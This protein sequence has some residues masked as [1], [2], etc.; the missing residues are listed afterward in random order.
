MMSLQR[1]LSLCRVVAFLP[2]STG[3]C[4]TE[5]STGSGGNAGASSSAGGAGCPAQPPPEGTPCS[6]PG[7]T[8]SYSDACCPNQWHCDASGVWKILAVP[9]PAP[10]PCPDTPPDDGSACEPCSLPDSCTFAC[11][12]TT[13]AIVGACVSGAWKLDGSC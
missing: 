4:S 12:G 8:C 9:C 10:G 1:F 13:A 6:A 7:T 3:A 11:L 5:V 2:L